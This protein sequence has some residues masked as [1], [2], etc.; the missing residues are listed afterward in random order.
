MAFFNDPV[1]YLESDACTVERIQ[2]LAASYSIEI[3]TTG[4]KD[5][6]KRQLINGFIRRAVELYPPTAVVADAQNVDAGVEALSR[7]TEHLRIST[8]ARSVFSRDEF[9]QDPMNYLDRCTNN[10]ITFLGNY[11]GVQFL[12]SWRKSE[13]K[14]HLI[15]ELIHKVD[16][17]GSPPAAAAASLE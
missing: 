12:V 7:M 13:L 14:K 5:E 10:Q 17:T 4:T 2:D 3:P 16:E 9:L 8:G 1:F 11:F 15:N 6:L